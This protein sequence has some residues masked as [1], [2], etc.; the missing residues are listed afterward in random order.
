MKSYRVT[1]DL[2]LEDEGHPRKWVADA[3]WECLDHTKGEDI[4]SIDIEETGYI[5]ETN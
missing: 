5:A 4:A 2:V 3:I 1:L